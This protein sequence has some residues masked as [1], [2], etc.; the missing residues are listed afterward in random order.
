MCV[1]VCVCVCVPV[2]E[3]LNKYSTFVFTWQLEPATVKPYMIKVFW[4]HV[5]YVTILIK[6]NTVV[7]EKFA[8]GNFHVKIFCVEIFSSSWV[9]NE[10]FLTMNNYLVEV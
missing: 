1:C 9:P 7:W 3:S 8:V 10:N 4:A 6:R 2:P 5:P